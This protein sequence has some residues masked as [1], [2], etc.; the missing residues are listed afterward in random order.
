MH[1]FAD[2]ELVGHELSHNLAGYDALEVALF[3]ATGTIMPEESKKGNGRLVVM[4]FWS[5]SASI[6]ENVDH[7]VLVCSCASFFQK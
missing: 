4:G 3:L 1:L 2:L 7:N 5:K 6:K